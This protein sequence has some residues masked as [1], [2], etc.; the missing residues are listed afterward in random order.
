M[1][2]LAIHYGR[3]YVNEERHRME[4]PA[5]TPTAP[6]SSMPRAAKI[7]H[8][9]SRLGCQRCKTR[10]VKV[11]MLWP[12]KGFV[13]HC[14][15]ANRNQYVG[16][17]RDMERNACTLKF[18]HTCPQLIV[19]RAFNLEGGALKLPVSQGKAHL[20]QQICSHAISLNA[21]TPR[22]RSQKLGD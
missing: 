21:T 9:K 8:K 19:Q 20:P 17:A 14:S 16:A 10:R 15:A 18:D 4:T 13:D 3:K 11:R 5:E 6:A 7:G 1:A 22:Y 2:T 12:A